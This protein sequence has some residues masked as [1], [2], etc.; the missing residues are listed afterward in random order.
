MS[1]NLPSYCSEYCAICYKKTTHKI[2]GKQLHGLTELQ[3]KMSKHLWYINPT[4]Y[5]ITPIPREECK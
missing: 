2:T 5:Q 4:L 1:I 3:G